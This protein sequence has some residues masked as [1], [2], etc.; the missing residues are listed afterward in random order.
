MSATSSSQ[1][2]V[3]LPRRRRFSRYHHT[4]PQIGLANILSQIL[5]NYTH[6]QLAPSSSRLPEFRKFLRPCH[7]GRL[8]CICSRG[9]G[10]QNPAHGA[11]RGNGFTFAL[12]APAGAIEPWAS[13]NASSM[14]RYPTPA[15]RHAMPVPPQFHPSFAPPGALGLVCPSTHG[16]RRGLGSAAAT[17]AKE[18]KTC[19][20]GSGDR[21]KPTAQPWVAV[22][23]SDRKPRQG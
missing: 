19:C 23:T 4:S 6:V 5:S 20:R 9:S 11:S 18:G 1:R 12:K 15:T 21:T 8:R 13:R 16:L 14:D 2:R 7:G 17:A 22:G 3:A 10:D